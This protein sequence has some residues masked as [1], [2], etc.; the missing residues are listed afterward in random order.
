MKN[1]PVEVS[2]IDPQEPYRDIIER[3]IRNFGADSIAHVFA[4][5]WRQF[6]LH[7]MKMVFLGLGSRSASNRAGTIRKIGVLCTGSKI[8]PALRRLI[9]L[10]R[11][12]GYEIRL[13]VK[14][15]PVQP[16]ENPFP[17]CP[18]EVYPDDREN[19][20]SFFLGPSVQKQN[21]AY[22]ILYEP[23]P[24]Y[25]L[26]AFLL[27]HFRF[28]C[29]KPV[30]AFLEKE[31]GEL[32]C[33]DRICLSAADCVLGNSPAID[34][35]FGEIGVLDTVGDKAAS[36]KN[37]ISAFEHDPPEG[38]YKQLLLAARRAMQTTAENALAE[39]GFIGF[40]NNSELDR[41]KL[42]RKIAAAG[43][44]VSPDDYCLL[45]KSGFFDDEYYRKQFPGCKIDDPILHFCSVGVQTLAAPSAIFDPKQYYLANPDLYPH[46]NPVVHYLRHGILEGRNIFFPVYDIIKNSGYFDEARYRREHKG[47][48]GSFEP[49]VHY[50][51]IGR[52]KGYLPSEFFVPQYYSDF[53]LDF[54]T[55]TMDPLSHYLLFGK[56]E[57]RC[58]FPSVPRI[59]S[60]FPD[61][62]DDAEGFWQRK[63][64]YLLA[65]HQLDFTGVP[66]LSKSIAE[67][68]CKEEKYAAIISPIDGPLRNACLDAGIP[69]LIDSSFFVRKE[70]A[71]F[72][73]GKGFNLCLFNTLV[74]IKSFLR[75]ADTIPSVL[76]IH[77]NLPGKALPKYVRD[78]IQFAPT[79]F[80]TSQT[81]LEIVREYNPGVR[82][83]P[84]PVK[85]M[86]GQPKTVVP[87]R[88]RF[89][90]MGV[91]CD[92]KGQDLVIEAF[93]KLPEK[94]KMKA[95]LLL[96]GNDDI[97]PDFARKL[98]TMARG[99]KH[100]HFLPAKKDPVAYHR[101]YEDMEVQICPSRTDPMPL[102]VFD[103]MM[104]GCPEILSD[105][106]GQSEFIR[107]GENGYVFPS[108]DADA[109]RDCM[110]RILE[111]PDRFISMS[112]AVR[113]T[114]LDNAE[115][116]KASGI[117]RRVLDEV[118]NYF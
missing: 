109:L 104:H 26:T 36:L 48:L 98:E 57:G 63:G 99:E 82:Y 53:Y 50:L 23:N 108:E 114:F 55:D 54:E 10:L 78:R 103:G 61:G 90:V 34:R 85:D 51:L 67:M 105:T 18:F 71:A 110:V 12:D 4:E 84:Y 88:I 56:K 118:K 43:S 6:G 31:I 15:D 75:V 16:E 81:T 1:M 115:F 93:I 2:V 21:D 102:V 5:N 113:Q 22:V 19:M 87:D 29:R 3:E 112:R 68:F 30:F 96:I 32:N 73:K 107:N 70:R 46:V 28:G 92:R 40:G 11:G 7:P 62:Y 38:Q 64:K 39:L 83:L 60:Y 69:V 59:A 24:D 52:K 58:I 33:H 13:F 45:R 77:D 65:V 14:K 37:I 95:E 9:E 42:E 66:I 111:A 86:G 101:L 100:I 97:M 117:I 89:G 8:S 49:L 47:E 79:I 72:Y 74:L 27:S 44:P 17:D 80:A 116:T 106:V 35:L 91:Y 41:K 94:L 25:D 20:I 76:W